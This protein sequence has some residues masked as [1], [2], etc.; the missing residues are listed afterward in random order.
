MCLSLG[1][2][3]LGFRVFRVLGVFR[4]L[5]VFRARSFGF[6]GSGLGFRGIG[7]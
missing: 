2:K 3:G 1:V 4:V 7:G 5:R 6:T